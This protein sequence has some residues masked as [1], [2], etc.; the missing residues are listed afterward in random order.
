MV[1]PVPTFED[2]DADDDLLIQEVMEKVVPSVIQYLG[3]TPSGNLEQDTL[4]L[5]NFIFNQTETRLK[6][7]L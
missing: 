7:A 2:V 3:G 6:D 1:E 5:Y 4:L